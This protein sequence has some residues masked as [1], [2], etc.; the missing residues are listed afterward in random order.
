MNTE[1]GLSV[2]LA[3]CP[4]FLQPL[5]HRVQLLFDVKTWQ[6]K[7]KKEELKIKNYWT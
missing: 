6:L 3:G 7:I 1:G 5:L 2:T 4:A